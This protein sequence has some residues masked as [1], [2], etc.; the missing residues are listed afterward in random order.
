M[1]MLSA[2]ITTATSLEEAATNLGAELGLTGPAPLA[3]TKRALDEP[4]YARALLGLRKNPTLRDQFLSSPG[5]A[6]ISAPTEASQA[7]PSAMALAKKATA[8]VLKWGMDGLKP[9]A[10]WVIARRLEACNSCEFQKP[11]PDTLVYRGAKV[12]VGKDAKICA[13]CDCLTNTKA[14][15]STERCPEKNVNNPRLSR[16]DEIWVTP[17]DHPEGPW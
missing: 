17:K 8:S 4:L 13:S 9:A 16:W 11:A 1:Q 5:T 7:T 3:A 6:K 10:P 12:V 2:A 15:I 14:A